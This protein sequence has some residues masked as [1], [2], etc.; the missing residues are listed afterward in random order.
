MHSPNRWGYKDARRKVPQ[1]GDED[2]CPPKKQPPES[3]VVW[4]HAMIGKTG[5]TFIGFNRR[6][7]Q[8]GCERRGDPLS[9]LEA[10]RVYLDRWGVIDTGNQLRGASETLR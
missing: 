2:V 6:K 8:I 1:I 9:Q 3:V 5:G 7:I 10:V 4:H